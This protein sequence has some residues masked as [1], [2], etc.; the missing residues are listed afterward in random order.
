MIV[1]IDMNS[2]LQFCKARQGA[3]DSWRDEN[4]D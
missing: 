4:I 1:P 2:P 3:S